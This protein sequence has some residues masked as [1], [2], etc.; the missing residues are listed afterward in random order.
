MKLDLSKCLKNAGKSISKNSP[1]ILTGLGLV[2]MVSSTILA[3]K[4]TPKAEELINERKSQLG[5][6]ND[7]KLPVKEAIKVA[8]KPYIPAIGTSIASIAC[9]IGASRINYKRNAAL[10]TAYTLSETTLR[11]YKNKV[12]DNIGEQ[13]EKKIVEEIAQDE[14]NEAKP[15]NDSQVI[16]TSGGNTLCYDSFSGRY[17]RSDMETIKQVVNKLN[18]RMNYEHYISLNEYYN[19]IGLDNITQGS[20]LGWNL[21]DGLIEPDFSTALA[22]DGNPCIVIDFLVRPKSEFDKLY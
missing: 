4:A 11:R 19:E 17:F 22:K 18:R 1:I 7:E 10:A 16:I 13:R 8:W 6:T 2:G 3:V 9:I 15:V 12:I 21:D 5:L 20:M 14:L